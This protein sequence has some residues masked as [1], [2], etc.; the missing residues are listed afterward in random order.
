MIVRKKKF[1]GAGYILWGRRRERE[2]G[3]RY[4]K[5]HQEFYETEGLGIKKDSTERINKH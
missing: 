2:C 1:T 4:E 5:K 3:T